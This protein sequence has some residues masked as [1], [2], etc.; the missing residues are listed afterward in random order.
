MLGGGIEA[1]KKAGLPTVVN[2]GVSRIS[3]MR[4]VQ[5]VIGVSVLVGSALAWFVDPRFVAI[6]AFFGAG[7]TFAGATG[8]CALASLIAR[9]PW[10]RVATAALSSD[11]AS[12]CSPG[13]SCS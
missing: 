7:L 10:N 3:V 9:L 6:P 4:Q 11:S 8:T 1:W 13:K 2:T 12:C 5:L